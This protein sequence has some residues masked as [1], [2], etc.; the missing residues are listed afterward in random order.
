MNDCSESRSSRSGAVGSVIVRRRFGFA[1]L[2][3]AGMKINPVNGSDCNEQA[4]DYK[5]LG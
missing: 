4:E 2:W 3:V 5:S 1:H